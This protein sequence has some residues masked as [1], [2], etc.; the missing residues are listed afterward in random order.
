MDDWQLL[1]DYARKGSQPAFAQIVARYVD[2]VYSS[3]L[4]QVRR[5]DLAEDITQAVFLVLARKAASLRPNVLL[6][7]WLFKTTRYACCN[8]LTMEARRKHHETVAAAMAPASDEPS[9]DWQEL[10]P[11]LDQA[12]ARLRRSDRD[13]VLLRFYGQR[14]LQ[15]VGAALGISEDAARKRI[16]RALDKL[17]TFLAARGVTLTIPALTAALGLYATQSAP[18]ALAA[19]ITAGVS[20]P[21]ALSI[22]QGTL[23][24]MMRLKLKAAAVLTSVFL[25]IGA[26]VTLNF[27]LAQESWLSRLFSTPTQ[28]PSVVP[29]QTRTV[30]LQILDR[31][32]GQP[33]PK[34]PLRVAVGDYQNAYTDFTDDQGLHR[35]Q[36]PTPDTQYLFVSAFPD[37]YAPRRVG[38]SDYQVRGR[39][40]DSYTLNLDPGTTIGGIV[41]DEQGNP[42]PNALVKISLGRS[43]LNGEMYDYRFPFT[44]DAAGRWRC[45]TLPEKLED[46]FYVT[47]DH[48]AY[49]PQNAIP[50]DSGPVTLEKLR[51]QTAEITVKKGLTIVGR[52]LDDQNRPIPNATVVEGADGWSSNRRSA[53]T[54]ADGRFEIHRLPPGKYTLTVL[55]RNHAPDL[56][57]A[58]PAGQSTPVEFRLAPARTLRARVVDPQQKPVP[59]VYVT[60]GRWRGHG[61]LAQRWTTD[62]NGLFTWPDAPADDVLFDLSKQGYAPLRDQTLSPGKEHTLVLTPR[63][64][65]IIRG[66]VVDAQTN[67]PIPNFTALSGVVWKEQSIRWD[68]NTARTIA[69]G[70][71]EIA[72]DHSDYYP[73][74]A[75]R[76]E[77]DGYAP[78]VSRTF[79]LDEGTQRFDFKLTKGTLPGGIVRYDDKPLAGADIILLT[80]SFPRIRDGKADPPNYI[81][82]RSVARSDA[83]GRFS[84]K[85]DQDDFRV[86]IVHDFGYTEADAAKLKNNPELPLIPWGSLEGAFRVGSKPA[87]NQLLIARFTSP[88][89]TEFVFTTTTDSQGHF[90][91]DRLPPGDLH[92]SRATESNRNLIPLGFANVPNAQIRPNDTTRLTLGGGGRPVTG[93]IVSDHAQLDWTQLSINLAT[94]IEL[95]EPPLPQNWEKLSDAQKEAWANDWFKTP[96]GARYKALEDAPHPEANVTLSPDGSFRFDDVPPARYTLSLWTKDYPPLKHEF[97]I[98]PTPTDAP[99]NLG[100]L[101]L[102]PRK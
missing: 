14:D 83:D 45:D 16:A 31:K 34:A 74:R 23:K 36:L 48:P 19:A 65:L 64:P 15:A 70:P 7:A 82:T 89:K 71:Y 28:K 33:I 51:Q 81:H 5:S 42:L 29:L 21:T 54:D 3:A 96:E 91:F 59:G 8:T 13:A 44:T 6:S 67:Q 94:E 18:A 49:L 86:A 52:V 17:R 87:A 68:R 60:T 76:I 38:W 75:V 90:R 95:P 99:L 2:Q 39:I 100:S 98:P 37:R 1:Q 9:A 61:S 53:Q 55:A 56:R 62:A 97:T 12:V 22:A 10:S 77:A 72:F 40:P 24:L 43:S 25:L 102:P 63:S 41:R 73:G 20:S 46:P 57:D 84:I 26:A 93:R 58:V 92:V 11:I 85:P 66:T 4:R 50:Q 78:A 27:A 79:K 32:T 101:K 47:V 80:S 88:L 30:T 35:I 69:S